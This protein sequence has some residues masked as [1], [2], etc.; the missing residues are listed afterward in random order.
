MAV[1]DH[2]PVSFQSYGET[3]FSSVREEADEVM[4]EVIRQLQQHVT[5]DQFSFEQRALAATLLQQLNQPVSS[6]RGA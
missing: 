2:C 3:S 5:S 6:S 1:H 4:G